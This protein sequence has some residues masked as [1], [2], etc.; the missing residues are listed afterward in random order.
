MMAAMI[1][2]ATMTVTRN[3]QAYMQTE[4][5]GMESLEAKRGS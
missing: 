3:D 5:R 2:T 1:M 4:L